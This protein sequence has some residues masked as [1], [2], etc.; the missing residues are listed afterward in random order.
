M[1]NYLW[2]LC[3]ACFLFFENQADAQWVQTT[4]PGGDWLEIVL[5]AGTYSVS[6]PSSN[7]DPGGA[8][9][10]YNTTP[11]NG[12]ISRNIIVPSGQDVLYADFGFNDSS[13]MTATIATESG[14]GPI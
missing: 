1:Q 2:T 5:Q 9:E 13:G 6:I 10:G 14:T 4:G 7:F 12:A 8:L 3:I 11:T